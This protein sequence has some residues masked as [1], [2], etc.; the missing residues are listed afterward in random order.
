MQGGEKYQAAYYVFEELAQNPA[1]QSIQSLL[2]QAISELHLGRMPEAE[3]A[4]KQAVELDPENADVIANSVVLNT[5][6]GKDI[7]TTMAQ[8]EKVDRNHQLLTD[9]AEKRSEFETACKRYSP[10]FEV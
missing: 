9:L 4:F 6:L 1:S 7:A 5:I 8:L 2:G 10:K 3:A